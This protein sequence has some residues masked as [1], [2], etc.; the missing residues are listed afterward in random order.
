M[1][2]YTKIAHTCIK[3]AGLTGQVILNSVQFETSGGLG[4]EC[5]AVTKVNK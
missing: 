4:L 1:T 5:S 3:L 2:Y